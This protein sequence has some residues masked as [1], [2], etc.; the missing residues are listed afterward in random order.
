MSSM[1]KMD[2]IISLENVEHRVQDEFIRSCNHRSTAENCEYCTEQKII[3]L[4]YPSL[5]NS[6]LLFFITVVQAVID[7]AVLCLLQSWDLV[8]IMGGKN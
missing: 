8:T 2:N 6:F 5:T 3:T 1:K 7:L 4:L